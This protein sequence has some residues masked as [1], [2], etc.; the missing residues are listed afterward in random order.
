M[1]DSVVCP[2]R[3]NARICL[4]GVYTALAHDAKEEGMSP[5]AEWL[6]DN[7]QACWP[8]YKTDAGVVCEE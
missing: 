3:N 4:R 6:L 5:A 2:Q 7:F 1:T 8:G